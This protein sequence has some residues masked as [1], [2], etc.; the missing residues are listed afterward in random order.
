[1]ALRIEISEP[2][3]ARGVVD[4]LM[5]PE[6]YRKAWDSIRGAHWVGITTSERLRPHAD[7]SAA[8]LDEVFAAC[9]PIMSS[10]PP[11][12]LELDHASR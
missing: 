7:G 11:A 5:D 2:T 1:V 9:I 10:P 3:D 4:V 6:D 12:P 8:G